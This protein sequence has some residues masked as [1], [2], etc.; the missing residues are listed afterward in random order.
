MASPWAVSRY[1]GQNGYR[2][3]LKS[4][5]M[6]VVGYTHDTV[7]R[8][9]LFDN[10]FYSFDHPNLLY[11]VDRKRE[12]EVIPRVRAVLAAK[13]DILVDEWSGTAEYASKRIYSFG[14]ENK[15]KQRATKGGWFRRQ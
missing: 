13:Y 9:M 3:H 14:V 12:A 6:K 11:Y 7:V 10:M 15:P 5:A 4:G 2:Y 1:L 8:V